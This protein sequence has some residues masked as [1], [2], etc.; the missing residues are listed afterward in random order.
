MAL[1]PITT[2]IPDHTSNNIITTITTLTANVSKLNVGTTT[3]QQ[4]V[5]DFVADVTLQPYIATRIISFFA[6]NMRPDHIMHVFFDGVNV[7]QYCAPAARNVVN[8]YSVSTITNTSDYRSI[9][10]NSGWGTAIYSDKNGVVAGQFNLPAARFKTGE[11]VMQ[12]SDVENLTLGADAYT[13]ISSAKF[14]ASNLTVTKQKVTLTTV[15]PVLS[16]TNTSQTL[17]TSN[18]QDII[19]TKVKDVINVSSFYEPIAQALTINTP[20][21]QPGIF[22]TSIDLFF[23]QKSLVKENGVTLYLCETRN[24]YPAG[25]SI[26]PFGTKHLTYDEISVS[27]DSQTPTTFTFD[28][29]VFLNNNVL[30]AFIV[31][32]DANDPD[33][34]VYTALLGDIDIYTRTQVSSQP[35]V[36]TAFY[37]ATMNQWTALQ[38]EYIKFQLN[39][40]SFSN[41]TGI[42]YLEN[43]NT[44]FLSVANFTYVN[45]NAG[46]LP[47]DY[48]FQSNDAT[49]PSV[50]TSIRGEIYYYDSSKELL[51][52]DDP[53]NNFTAGKFIQIHRF[54]DI[55]N[56]TIISS[57]NSS[58]LV[59]YANSVT[60]NNVRTN[61]FVPQLSIMTPPGTAI[62][63]DYYGTTNSVYSSPYTKDTSPQ[64]LTVG[65]ETEFYDYERI[66]ASRTNEKINMSSAKS[67][68][69]AANMF[70][71]SEYVSPLI[72]M[73][74]NQE[75]CISN[76]IDPVNFDYNEFFNN[77]SNKTKY[78][79]Q[80]VTLAPGQEAQDLTLSLTAFRPTGS[81]IQVWVKFK[82]ASD[83]E[84]LANKTWTP[85]FNK[86][87]LVYSDPN[88]PNDFRE[89]NFSIAGSYPLMYTN[90]TITCTNT[91]TSV[92]GSGTL[93]DGE[94]DPG[95]FIVMKSGPQNLI[96]NTFSVSANTKGAN[97]TT[98]LIRFY[99][100]NGTLIPAN[101]YFTAGDRIKYVVPTDNTAISSSP[102]IAN[103]TY[104]YVKFANSSGIVLATSNTLTT[105][106]QITES[107]T[108]N[109]GETH[110]MYHEKLIPLAGESI[111]KVVS[112]TSNTA[113]T[114]DSPFFGN[115]TA[116]QYFKAFPPTTAWLSK[117]YRV[118]RSGT[119]SI[120]TSNN[121]VIGNG[122][123]FT[124]EL[125]ARSV[126]S[127]AGDV[128]QVISITNNSFLTVGSVW[129]AVAND[130]VIEEV[131]SSGLTYYDTNL[132]LYN[133]FN[134][135]Q[136]KIILQSNDTSK[137]PKIN[138]LRAL[139]L[140]L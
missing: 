112:I 85:M 100:S 128:Q 50:N 14:V 43:T 68:T 115:Y 118:L 26:L 91:S 80:P 61:A 84:A 16:W 57:P 6:Y 86:S 111:R 29:P 31:K 136:I 38:K 103:N 54:D 102:A 82:N 76:E 113:L 48:V 109:P 75:L 56:N 34:Q 104:Y 121:V 73:V 62:N 69:I 9:P 74:R 120:N 12:I 127:I 23:K 46:I 134:Q 94:L 58:T 13:S 44:E 122:T 10:R 135:F 140:Q 25:D 22:A 1:N 21:G 28:A 137:V 15:N 45:T 11:R 116:N 33:Y 129:G 79:S 90:G 19:I 41:P 37:G 30:Y 35:V 53:I 117:N 20:D 97:S 107:R 42:A 93:F 71:D 105:N 4:S 67:L 32:P 49:I 138:D 36:G 72:D 8:N 24:G 83:G 98:D 52:I 59:A 77:G 106:I 5:G 3:S 131:G 17:V 18:T 89:L 47:G 40:A 66:V 7:D 133:T 101:T 64:P 123:A 108:T 114:L 78:I 39:R 92:S 88:D 55:S 132:S 99:Y 87:A 110:Y 63:F 81:D 124:T 51:Y 2:P 125:S 119:V 65:Y 130:V 96:V 70:T 27:A 60:I 95:W 126:V 139:A